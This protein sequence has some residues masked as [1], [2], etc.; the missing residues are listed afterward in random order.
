MGQ[1][2]NFPATNFDAWNINAA[3]NTHVDVQA[4]HGSLIRTIGAASTVLLKNVNGALPLN[5]PESIG[6]IGMYTYL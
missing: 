6:I 2:N 1:D 4:D 5:K 3:V